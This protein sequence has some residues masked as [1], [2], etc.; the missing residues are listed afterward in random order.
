MMEH[1]KS[2]RRCRFLHGLD[3]DA[4]DDW[5]GVGRIGRAFMTRAL[6]SVL[7]RLSNIR[8]RTQ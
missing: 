8:F 1:I 5:R 6:F 2:G 3:G 7:T 4:Q